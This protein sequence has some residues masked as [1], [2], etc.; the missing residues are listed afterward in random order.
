MQENPSPQTNPQSIFVNFLLIYFVSQWLSLL[1]NFNRDLVWAATTYDQAGI[2]DKR[3]LNV[4]YGFKSQQF[5]QLFYSAIAV[6]GT[7]FAVVMIAFLI[8]RYTPQK[9][10]FK[11]NGKALAWQ[12]SYTSIAVL[13][14]IYCW[15]YAQ[16]KGFE[17]CHARYENDL[18][19]ANLC[20]SATPGFFEGWVQYVVT[21]FGKFLCDKSARDQLRNEFA[22]TASLHV[23]LLAYSLTFGAIGGGAWQIA[24]TLGAFLLHAGK[25][26]TMAMV[27]VTVLLCNALSG[28]GAIYLERRLANSQSIEK[29]IQWMMNGTST[30]F[31]RLVEPVLRAVM[32]PVLEPN[33]EK[34]Q[35]G[36]LPFPRM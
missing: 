17:D 10:H 27:A 7:A 19:K 3:T 32:E 23:A 5:G 11:S 24:F 26:G 36:S 25:Y 28:A 12:A 34:Q 16:Q 14:A 29:P 30:F 31:H 21:T 20:S 15:D 9:S 2:E 22:K 8:N 6:F 35:P 1:L 4:S 13:V 18:I 33:T